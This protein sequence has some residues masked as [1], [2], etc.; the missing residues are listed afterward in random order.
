[1]EKIDHNRIIKIISETIREPIEKIDMESKASDF[2]LLI[3][4]FLNDPLLLRTSTPLEHVLEF[5]S[6][7]IFLNSEFIIATHPPI[8]FSSLLYKGYSF[9]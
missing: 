2:E 7:S 3:V 9:I 1:M 8:I 6:T 5:T 4:I